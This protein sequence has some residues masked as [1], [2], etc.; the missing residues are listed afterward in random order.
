MSGFAA[1]YSAAREGASV[2]IIERNSALGGVGT[3]A[4]VN[5]ILGV[6]AIVDGVLTQCVGGVFSEIEKRILDAGSGVDVRNIDFTLN[7]HGWYPS[8]GTGL[9]F[10]CEK[11][12][13]LLADIERGN[14][15]LKHRIFKAICKGEI[16]GFSLKGR[17]PDA[18]EI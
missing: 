4:L 17:Y 8:L 18:G 2:L 6:R 10:D 9:I 15:G 14:K 16:D 3:S 7:P 13:L 1:A 12:K 5:H 11:M